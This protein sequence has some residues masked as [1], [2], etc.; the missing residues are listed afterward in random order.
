MENRDTQTQGGQGPRGKPNQ[1][2]DQ[3]GGQ[4]GDGPKGSENDRQREGQGDKESVRPSPSGVPNEGRGTESQQGQHQGGRQGHGGYEYKGGRQVQGG[5]PNPDDPND[6]ESAG[7]FRG[8]ASQP[9]A[10]NDDGE[11]GL[12]AGQKLGR[13]PSSQSS[14]LNENPDQRRV[15]SSEGETRHPL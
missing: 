11:Q 3:K 2:S 7:S 6:Q 12:G 5:V 8:T 9:G 15:E 14:E 1:R 13:N 10:D 4:Q